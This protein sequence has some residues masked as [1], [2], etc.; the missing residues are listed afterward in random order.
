MISH[1][2]SISPL[3]QDG[4]RQFTDHPLVGEVRG[5]GLV[6]AVELVE[7]K[8]SKKAF[9][10][11]RKVGAYLD[12]LAKENGMIVRAMGDNI[13]FTP[14]LIMKKSEI[15]EMVEIM[16]KTLDQTWAAVQAGEV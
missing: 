16:G 12:N 4:L 9:D 14:P 7:D 6:A 8:A 15:E 1:V 11:A 3:M 10:P 5:V 2:Q 13:G